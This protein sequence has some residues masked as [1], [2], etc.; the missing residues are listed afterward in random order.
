MPHFGA[1]CHQK[2]RDEHEENALITNCLGGAKMA[3]SPFAQALPQELW[4]AP[5]R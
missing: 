5:K 1:T 4:K 3:V 2:C